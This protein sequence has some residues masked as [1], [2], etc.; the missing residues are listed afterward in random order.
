[1]GGGVE[2]SRKEDL[3][4]FAPVKVVN[5]LQE[6]VVFVHLDIPISDILQPGP[7]PGYCSGN[8]LRFN[9][10]ST[11]LENASSYCHQSAE[12]T[13]P[14]GMVPSG[15]VTFV[16]GCVLS[17]R[18][19]W[20]LETSGLGSIFL[21]AFMFLDQSPMSPPHDYLFTYGKYQPFSYSLNLLIKYIQSS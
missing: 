15:A 5:F 2:D 4:T 10:I 21:L 8:S 3:G 7:H 6:L 1:M 16:Q 18:L 14:F 17:M 9:V 12:P 13:C 20:K 19:F 11:A